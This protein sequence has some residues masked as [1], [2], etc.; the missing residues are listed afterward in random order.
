M[1]NSIQTNV[2]SIIAQNNLQLNNQFKSQTID[3]LTSGF[4]INSSSDD[5]AG[6][7]VAN[8]FRTDVAEL[9][10]GVR[11]ANDGISVLQIIDGGLTN[12]SQMVDRM[13]TLATQSASDT[14]S[15]DRGTLN[16]EYQT[17]LGEI[18]RQAQNIGLSSG[19][20]VGARY[21]QN[22]GVYIGGAAG[23]QSNAVVTVHMGGSQVDSVGLGIQ[24]TNVLGGA[25]SEFAGGVNLNAAGSILGVGGTQDFTVRTA[26]MTKTVT[27]TG[28]STAKGLSA[29]DVV[30]QFNEQLNG[31]GISAA[32]GTD[33][34][35]NFYGGNTAF[36]IDAT[37]GPGDS[38]TA[39]VAETDLTN[40]NLNNSVATVGTP[41]AGDKLS[42]NVNGNSVVV[43]ITVADT[44]QTIAG[45]VNTSLNAY[46]IQAVVDSTGA[47]IN[48][49]GTTAFTVTSS[50]A[51][52]AFAAQTA[53]TSGAS[54]TA[55]ANSALA[56][57]TSA[58]TNLGLVQGK[59]GTGQN[60]LQYA[61][62][63]ANSQIASFSAAESRIRDADV[64]AEAANLTKAQ[65]LSQSSVAAL[66]QANQTP[67]VLLSLIKNA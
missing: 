41:A 7:A 18:N 66:A 43:D 65:V 28:D 49:E 44:T 27:L 40:K 26:S 42:F 8:Q 16:S 51:N 58:V 52:E 47:A 61:V 21:S 54:N 6:L 32:L 63:L 10:Q 25:G 56:A 46:G 64:A 13:K 38:I 9:N 29:S 20:G 3:R 24:S 17:L 57:L 67:Q 60:Q 30:N 14:F 11:N 53:A 35:L 48:M 45:K 36:S 55:N 62:N 19:A 31:T 12:I 34:K 59:V 2:D 33:G 50:T 15:G 5:A 23:V 22:I 37:A 1:S 39:G 4:R